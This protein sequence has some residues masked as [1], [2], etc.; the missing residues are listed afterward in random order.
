MITII[1]NASIVT[2]NK[3]TTGDVLIKDGRIETIAPH[4]TNTQTNYSEVNGEGCYLIPGVI[5]DQVHFREPG[6]E[7][8][9]TIATESLAAIAGGVTSFIDQP[10]V[11]PPTTNWS[12]F[13]EK[14]EIGNKNSFANYGFNI[15]ATNENLEDLKYALDLYSNQIA[16]VKVFMGS[17]TGNM[18]VDNLC[19]LEEIFKLPKLIITHCEDELTIRRNLQ[20]F[21]D[22]HGENIPVEK[23]P[24]IRSKEACIKSSSAAVALAKKIG[25]TRLHVYHISTEDELALFTNNLPLAEKK[26]TAEVCLHHLWF[27][28]DDYESKGTLIKWNPAV[29]DKHHGIALREA[30][31]NGT[32]DILATDHAPHTKDEKALPYTTCPSGAPMVQHLLPAAIKL[33]GI[34]NLPLLVEKF[35]HNPAILFG[36]KDR[37]YIRE[38]YYADL[39]LIKPATNWTVSSENILYNCGWSPLQ[40]ETFNTQVMA[41][42][43]NGEMVYDNRKPNPFGIG[44]LPKV[45]SGMALL[46]ER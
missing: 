16:G 11:K 9:G 45:A 10:N 36:I 44:I 21:I 40:N 43:V 13:A 5:D 20:E 35:C 1:K 15:G 46:F 3:I 17:S 33:F 18:L 7:H 23:H 31:F 22:I 30:L 6:L 29:K 27:N 19:M 38:G 37:G 34:K 8:K 42:F 32:L 26:I 41:T 25:T 12:L 4:I 39:V 28:T 2:G 14:L 24:I